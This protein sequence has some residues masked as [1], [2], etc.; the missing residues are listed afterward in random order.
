MTAPS[1]PL[2]PPVSGGPW[3]DLFANLVAGLRAVVL[4][5]PAA[6]RWRP[7]PQ[8]V[9]LITLLDLLAA[10]ACNL[11]QVGADGVFAWFALPRA[12]LPVSLALLAGLAVALA[13]RLPSL[14]MAIATASL[15]TTFWFDLAWGVLSIAE[16][17]AWPLIPG[18]H[19]WALYTGL[20]VWWA[21]ALGVAAIRIIRTRWP[22]RIVG[23]AWVGLVVALPFWWIPYYP[24]WQAPDAEQQPGRPDALLIG[25][26]DIFYA[27]PDLLGQALDDIEPERPGVE[28]LYF[29]GVAGYASEDVFMNEVGL[30]AELLR[31]RFDTEGRSVTLVNNPKTVEVLPVASATSLARTLK[32]LG[33]T[34]D[35]EED[36]VFV[37]L[38]SHGSSTHAVAMEFWPLQLAAIT[39]ET[40]KAMLDE[41]GI[42]WRIIV[43]SACYSGGFIKA[44]EDENTLIVTAADADHQSFGCGA[45]SDLTYFGKAYFDEALRTTYSFTTA[46]EQARAAIALRE[47]AQKYEPSNPQI[48]IGTGMAAKLDR[49][50]RRFAGQASPPLHEARCGQPGS[51]TGPCPSA[52][53]ASN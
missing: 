38:T 15:A 20:F 14:L 53:P 5:P 45:D 12:V 51:I 25:R 43:V 26:E 31:D 9:L 27:Q 19:T 16:A 1:S 21:V 3:P 11:A 41:A 30:A 40:L 8:Q 33:E 4:L 32:V 17:R 34:I 28:D 6:G 18:G 37:F 36:V 48:F 2:S 35:P 13:A 50:E 44:L 7:F 52:L 29:V 23:G 10:L 24:L 42:R 39:P 46:F 49:M 47:Q 22:L